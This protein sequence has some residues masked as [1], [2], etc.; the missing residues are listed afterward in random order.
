MI[1]FSILS[2]C[3]ALCDDT[4]DKAR[5]E[6]STYES[7]RGHEELKRAQGSG[8]TCRGE[9]SW[10]KHYQARGTGLCPGRGSVYL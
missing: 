10:R 7:S 9:L 8:I 4:P 6:E 1:I 3:L 2:V 5:V